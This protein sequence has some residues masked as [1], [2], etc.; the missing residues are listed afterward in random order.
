[1]K[2]MNQ[3]SVKKA[4]RDC[5]VSMNVANVSMAMVTMNKINEMTKR[6]KTV[7]VTSFLKLFIIITGNTQSSKH[8]H[9]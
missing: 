2:K 8:V 4:S 1:M 9:E 5:K 3:K 7:Q 6:Q